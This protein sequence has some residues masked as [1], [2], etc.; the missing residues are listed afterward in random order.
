MCPL[1]RRK[2]DVDHVGGEVEPTHR[3]SITGHQILGFGGN[4]H[5][6]NDF[7]ITYG[8]HE[9]E[10]KDLVQ[11]KNEMIPWQTF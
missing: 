9:L 8:C 5:A 4:Y 11:Y 7:A 10:K 3:C 1:C 6:K 2:C